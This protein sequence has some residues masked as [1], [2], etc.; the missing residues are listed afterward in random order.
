MITTGD[1]LHAVL[2]FVAQVAIVGFAAPRGFMMLAYAAAVLT[3]SHLWVTTRF[4]YDVVHARPSSP[5]KEIASL[6]YVHMITEGMFLVFVALVW[7]ILFRPA[8]RLDSFAVAGLVR[9]V[10]SPWVPNV[11]DR[12]AKIVDA[13]ATT[14]PM[15]TRTPMGAT[16]A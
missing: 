7:D 6:A 14:I 16:D 9:L 3:M 10:A 2:V 11:T 5:Q 1:M 15:R 12:A 4:T 13:H 8:S